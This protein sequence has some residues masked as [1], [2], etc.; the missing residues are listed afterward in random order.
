LELL[1]AGNI[2]SGAVNMW[3]VFKTIGRVVVI[4]KGN[5]ECK[6]RALKEIKN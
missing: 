1:R 6:E 5:R 3:I 2:K 4:Y